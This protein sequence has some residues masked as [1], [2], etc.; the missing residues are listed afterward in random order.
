MT[1]LDFLEEKLNTIKIKA[2]LQQEFII[3]YCEF[4]NV[5]CDVFKS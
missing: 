4:N 5:F 3:I 1:T 2:V